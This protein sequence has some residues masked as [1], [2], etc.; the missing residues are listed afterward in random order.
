M[1][2]DEP[3]TNKTGR[4]WTATHTMRI[5]C[6]SFM[7]GPCAGLGKFVEAFFN[8]TAILLLFSNGSGIEC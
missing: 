5:Y 1:A 2:K 4:Y 8:S 3:N 7:L 6:T